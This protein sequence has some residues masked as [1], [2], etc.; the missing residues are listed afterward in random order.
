[1]KHLFVSEKFYSIQGEGVSTGVP[2]IFLRLSGCNILC[3]SENW[4]C[5]SI[6]VW[7]KGI[8]TS[9]ED[10]LA[11]KDYTNL[12]LGAHLVV[13]GGEPLLHQKTL[14]EFFKWI[15]EERF[16]GFDK[17]PFF[18]E[19]ETNGTIMPQ[20]EFL[21]YISQ[22][23]CSPKLESSG[24]GYH[25]RYKKESLQ[26]IF[27]LPNSWGKFVISKP[28]DYDEILENFLMTDLLSDDQVILMPAGDSQEL[29]NES[30][31]MVLDLCKQNAVR[32]SDRLHIV[33]W[34]QKT[35]V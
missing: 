23:N 5:D 19:V 10:V 21:A 33:A 30:R 15:E 11:P 24:E 3:K 22:W 8:K 29:L 1:M 4:I 7:Q 6:E 2:A 32:Y 35:G 18:V 16:P 26:K 20:D 31:S 12:A 9:F 14:I 17:F 27:S 28:E 34:N 13:T 25:R